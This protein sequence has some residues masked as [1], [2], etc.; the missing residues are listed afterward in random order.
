[1]MMCQPGAFGKKLRI[2]RSD[3]GPG[4]ARRVGV[5]AFHPTASQGT[6]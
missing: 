2:R 1:M 4:P 6:W 3:A 5:N